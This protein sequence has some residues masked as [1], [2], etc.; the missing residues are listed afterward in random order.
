MFSYLLI[1]ILFL[2]VMQFAFAFLPFLLPVILVL[3]IIS[4]FRKPNVHVYQS[5][6]TFDHSQEN[7][8]T[9]YR[10]G[11]T[12][13]KRTEMNELEYREPL[14]GSIDAEYTEVHEER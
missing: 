6:Y 13:R 7:P 9:F 12:D 11:S 8:Y 14:E 3:W 2:L 1:F 4:L 5:T 10:S